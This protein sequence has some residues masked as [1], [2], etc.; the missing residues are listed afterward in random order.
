MDAK[1]LILMETTKQK[2]GYL[3]QDHNCEAAKR[4]MAAFFV[5]IENISRNACGMGKF[6][7]GTF[8]MDF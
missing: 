7:F 4:G 8:I 2:F 6:V 3:N 1:L 5:V